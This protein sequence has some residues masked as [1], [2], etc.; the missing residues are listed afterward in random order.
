MGDDIT[1]E[2][3]LNALRWALSRHGEVDCLDAEEMSIDAIDVPLRPIA[4]ELLAALRDGRADEMPRELDR[5]ADIYPPP[6]GERLWVKADE[7]Y[8]FGRQHYVHRGVPLTSWV[9]AMLTDVGWVDPDGEPFPITVREWKFHDGTYMA[10]CREW[11]L[12][13]IW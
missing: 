11:K 9:P 5:P 3:M 6:H 10:D 7:I 12:G 8:S 1:L 4:E 2:Q 13:Q